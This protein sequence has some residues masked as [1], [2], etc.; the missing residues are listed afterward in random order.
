[1]HRAFTLIEL[2]VVISIIAI[3]I[4]ILLPALSR[5]RD[6]AQAVKCL[7]NDRQI[8]TAAYTFATDNQQFIFPESQMY[9]G[10][11]YFNVLQ[12]GGYLPIVDGI[13]RCPADEDEGAADGWE[14]NAKGAPDPIRTTSYAING[15]FASNHDPYGDPPAAHG[16]DNATPGEFG[17]SFDDVKNP[18][19]KVFAAEIA[20]YRDVDHFMP[21]YWGTSAGIHP[22]PSSGMYGMA[23]MSQ[24][25]AANGNVPRIIT[26]DRHQRGSH[27]AFADG[28]AAFH[29]FDETWDDTITDRADRDANGKTDWYDPKY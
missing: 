8:A 11:G 12:G 7:S 13:H 2:L 4:G 25:D 10:A 16:G 15:Y 29:T 20:E 3:L 9:G 19:R 18:A 1:M 14:S 26:R 5:A 27:F 24:I 23:R 22:N 28:H 21:M 6:A 17:L